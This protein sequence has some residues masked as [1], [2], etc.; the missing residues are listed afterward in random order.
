[1]VTAT[2]IRQHLLNNIKTTR[3]VVLPP[4]FIENVDR[5]LRILLQSQSHFN[6]SPKELELK[7]REHSGKYRTDKVREYLKTGVN[8]YCSTTDVTVNPRYLF[9]DI[10]EEE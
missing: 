5:E 1:M 3:T 6:L 9:F 7:L 10:P 8:N 4:Y 2:D